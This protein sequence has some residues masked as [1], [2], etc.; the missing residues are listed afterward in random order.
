MAQNAFGLPSLFDPSIAMD[1]AALDRQMQLAAALRAQSMAP[2]ETAGR[3]IGGMAYRVSPLEG[4]AKIVQAVSANQMDRAND[5]ARGGLAQKNLAALA[6]MLKGGEMPA[7]APDLNGGRPAGVSA[8]SMEAGGFPQPAAGAAA[9]PAAAPADANGFTLANLLRGSAIEQV[10]GNAMAGAYAKNFETPEAIRTLRAKG[11]DPQN[12]GRLETAK[13]DREVNQPMTLGKAAYWDPRNGVQGLPSQIPGAVAVPDANAP[14][15]FRYELSPGAGPAMEQQAASEAF[16]KAQAT[17]FSGKDEYGRPQPVQPLAAVLRGT[18]PS[19]A[20]V[21]PAQQSERDAARV[22]ILRDELAVEKD[23][24]NR[25]LLEKEIG[26]TRGGQ[27]FARGGTYTEA[28]LGTEAAQKGLDT[29]W[30]ALK[31]SNREAAN[32]KSFLD[33]IVTAVERGAIH[34]PQADRRE[35]IAGLLQ[36]AG[37]KESANEDAG[38]QKQLLD[39]YSNQIVARLGA[40]GGLATDAARAI[41]ASAYPNSSMNTAA[42][43]EAAANLKGAQDMVQAKARFLQDSAIK[44][45]TAAY[46]QRELAFDQAADPRIWQALGIKDVEK[47]RALMAEIIRQDPGIAERIK[48]LKEMG[49]L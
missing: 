9:P 17:P 11:Q 44:R 27:A 47:R 1:Q 42:I 39:K 31:A 38:A 36:L 18:A 12:V 30:E 13:L 7:A 41:V 20:Q 46:Q 3:Q 19:P 49:A 29:S 48:A 23:P 43:R 6:A 14:G 16:G 45:D 33:N 21:S 26:G 8:A 22:K 24:E 25:R 34:G 5:R 15:K 28:P 37:I 35:M 4:I 32:T 40:S 2:V 10:G